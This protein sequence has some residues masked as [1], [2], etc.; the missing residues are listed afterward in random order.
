MICDKL[1]RRGVL[2]RLVSFCAV[3]A[4][5]A[6]RAS[7]AFARE[8]PAALSRI[9]GRIILRKDANYE[10]W[11]GSMVWYLFKPERY[12]SAMIRA[13]SEQDVIQAI[14]HARQNGQKVTVRCTGH[15]PPGAVLRD[16]CVLV[17][18]SPLRG[19]QIDA[20][21]RTAWIDPGIR[22][23]DL[24]DA[25]RQKGLAFPA[26]H[27]SIVGLG[28]YLLGG[29]LGW[30]MSEWDIACR[31]ILAADIV[32]ADGRKLRASPDENPDLFWALRGVGPGFFGAVTRFKL[33]LYPAPQ[34]IAKS[35]YLVPV[36]HLAATTRVLDELARTKER[37]VEILAV[38]GHFRPPGTPPRERDRLNCVVSVFVFGHSNEDAE[39]LL[40]PVAQ[41]E[42][43]RRAIFSKER[44]LLSFPELYAGQS[45][46]HS[47]PNRT[48]V[49]NMWTDRPGASLLT[50]AERLPRTASPRS[51]A[52]SAWGVRPNPEDQ[53]S[54]W[55]Y[56][57]DHYVSWYCIAEEQ[58]HI[59]QNDAWMAQTV[60]RM[61]P[62]S[63]GH[64]IN[65][66]DPGRY[67]EH[68]RG[69]FSGAKWN[70]L[71]QLRAKYDPSGVFHS[72]L[73]QS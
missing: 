3:A 73:G 70:R 13:Q 6:L 66:I 59:E 69:C 32:M 63:K 56:F 46:D 45:T 48:A 2:A 25:T 19:V 34:V 50:L 31:S 39:E 55:T 64:Y 68:L 60:E 43:A 30:N 47:S 72:Y 53:E 1:T 44:V 12:P 67:P 15:N 23:Q 18:L 11:R 5:G 58:A 51:F 29:G 7:L 33:Q 38:V 28:G 41:S 35:Q 10:L 37:R 40:K 14:H 52:L 36:E 27:T 4:F 20:K 22:S 9:R 21:T 8:L 61:R 17:D 54:S 57:A 24:M 49:T 26:A 62:L 71:T 65:E 42:I 16:D